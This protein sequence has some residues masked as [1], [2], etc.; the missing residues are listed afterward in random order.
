MEND[1]RIYAT[2]EKKHWGPIF[3]DF[4]YLS[5]MGFPVT[6]TAE[7]SREFSNLIRNF[8]VFLPCAECRYHYKREI[9]NFNF[10][11]RD[12]NQAIDVVLRLHNQ[13]RKRQNKNTLTKEDVIGYHYRKCNKTLSFWFTT[14][15]VVL[16]ILLCIYK[17]PLRPG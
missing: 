12:K 6:L 17:I 4:L 13:V 15:F 2:R 9:K 11:V 3:W 7:Q 1:Y 5:V 14:T 10:D 8:H 16:V